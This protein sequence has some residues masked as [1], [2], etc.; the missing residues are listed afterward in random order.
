MNSTL[1][2]ATATTA[3]TVPAAMVAAFSSLKWRAKALKAAT[4]IVVADDFL[5]DPKAAAA[6][7]DVVHDEQAV[8][9]KGR[10]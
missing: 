9:V 5:G 6:D 2:S 1:Y 3:A 8:E 10:G 7:G 4:Q